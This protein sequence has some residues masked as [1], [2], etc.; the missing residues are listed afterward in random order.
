MKLTR[1]Q[2]QRKNLISVLTKTVKALKDS[3]VNYHWMRTEQCNCGILAQKAMGINKDELDELTCDEGHLGTWSGEASK[4]LKC[5]LTGEKMSSVF[6]KLFSLGLTHKDIGYIEFCENPEVLNKMG[7][8]LNK[9]VDYKRRE[10]VARYFEA[11]LSIEKAKL[12]SSI[13]KSK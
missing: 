8:P 10:F 6:K 9:I 3:E 1:R 7:I 2:T 13:K 11:M 4:Q 12:K 5:K